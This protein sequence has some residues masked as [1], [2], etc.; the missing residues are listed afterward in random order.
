M[1]CCVVRA[2]F[3][4]IYVLVIDFATNVKHKLVE[5]FYNESESLKVMILDKHAY[6]SLKSWL[7]IWK[8]TFDLCISKLM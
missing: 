6:A 8:L 7:N 5:D 1:D 3:E 2:M 4:E